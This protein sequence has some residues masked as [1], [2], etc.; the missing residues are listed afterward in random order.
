MDKIKMLYEDIPN[1]TKVL[2]KVIRNGSVMPYVDAWAF[3]W[4]EK[5]DTL[6]TGFR[7]EGNL[8]KT[9]FPNREN[10]AYSRDLINAYSKKGVIIFYGRPNKDMNIML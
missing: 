1:G 7:F 5:D 10:Y 3:T 8:T 6:K 2:A 4:Y 9:L